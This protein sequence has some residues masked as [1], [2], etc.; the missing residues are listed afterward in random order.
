MKLIRIADK[1]YGADGIISECWDF[2]KEC[3]IPHR[4]SLLNGDGMSYFIVCELFETYQA[5]SS[6]EN[7]ID[8]AIRVLMSA[9][10]Q[11]NSVIDA[12]ARA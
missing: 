11:L 9:S 5:T 8:E 7:Q 3:P 6:R 12:V 4:Q 10:E 1:A 2:N